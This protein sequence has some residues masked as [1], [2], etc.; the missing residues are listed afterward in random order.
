VAPHEP[1]CFQVPKDKYRYTG[2]AAGLCGPKVY[3]LSVFRLTWILL[4]PC[5]GAAAGEAVSTKKAIRKSAFGSPP[6]PCPTGIRIFT[7]RGRKEDFDPADHATVRVMDDSRA[8]GGAYKM[9]SFGAIAKKTS[10][11]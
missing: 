3:F 10:D 11:G 8:Q 2:R 5:L 7:C 6:A 9:G 1:A 4:P